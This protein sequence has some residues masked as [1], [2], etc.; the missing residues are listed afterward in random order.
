MT[1]LGRKRQ[2]ERADLITQI[3]QGRR[4][5]QELFQ[6]NTRSLRTM[7]ELLKARVFGSTLWAQSLRKRMTKHVQSSGPR[8]IGHHLSTDNPGAEVAQS[9]RAEAQDIR[10]RVG[11]DTYVQ[12]GKGHGAQGEPATERRVRSHETPHPPEPH[13]DLDAEEGA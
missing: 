12:G 6:E 7:G 10:G 13:P 2:L 8:D 9:L 11:P 4:V 5:E 3:E 1:L